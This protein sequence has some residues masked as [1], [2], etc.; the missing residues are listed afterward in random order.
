MRHS[1]RMSMGAMSGKALI[2]IDIDGANARKAD[3]WDM[4]L[5]VRDVAEAPDGSV[6]LL[7]DGGRRGEGRLF[8]LTPAA[9]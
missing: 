2:H 9:S 7:E 1:S 5:R 4:G 8:R 3:Q 6:F